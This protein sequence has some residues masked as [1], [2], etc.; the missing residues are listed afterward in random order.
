MRNSEV[1]N[2]F[3]ALAKEKGLISEDKKEGATEKNL[4]DTNRVGSLSIEQIAKL[5]N[6][7][8]KQPEGMEYDH[9]IMEV[10]HKE[11]SI[12]APSYDKLN[13]LAPSEIEGQAI[14]ARITM[15]QPN[16]QNTQHKYAEKQLILSLVRLGNELDNADQEPLRKLADTCLLQT[17]K[18]KANIT[19]LAI[20]F[21]IYPIAAALGAAYAKQHMRFHSDGFEADYQKAIA[22][23]DDLLTSNSNFGVGYSYTPEFLTIV[24]KLK[25]Q[26]D[27]LHDGVE[28]VM[29]V[30]D[31]YQT[32]HNAQELMQGA[33]HPT[34]QAAVQAVKD[35]RSVVH[36]SLPEL[37]G[38][39]T[40]F[41]NT[42]FKQRAIASKGLLSGLVDSAG[43][44]GGYGLVADDFDDVV[45]ALQTLEDDLKVIASGLNKAATIQDSFQQQT[46]LAQSHEDQMFGGSGETNPTENVSQP[47]TPPA[48]P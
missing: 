26:L 28:K 47:A 45:R 27:V 14:R 48:A 29:P 42:E 12:V 11:P 43:L 44:H 19:K 20:P 6:T 18:K 4:K 35:L 5:Y 30:L 23:I 36:T 10:A 38:A 16:G 37:D 46:E 41:S 22:E 1:F 39:I 40:S 32:P 24:A 13:G 33:S 25:A 15:K 21:L 3:I 7:K 17:T 2:N 31:A 9:N 34:A 8:T